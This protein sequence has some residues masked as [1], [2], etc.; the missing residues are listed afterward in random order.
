MNKKLLALVL[1]LST[2]LSLSSCAFFGGNKDESSSSQTSEAPATTYDLDGAKTLLESRVKTAN[3]ESRETYEV[4]ASILLEDVTYTI[5]WSVDVETVKI[6]KDGDKVY[7]NVYEASL[8]FEDVT[9][10]L[11][12]KI[13]APDGSTIES[14]MNRVVPKLER[15]VPAKITEKP[16]ENVAYKL[17]VYQGNTQKEVYAN[18]E[19]KNTWYFASTTDYDNGI[20]VYAEH[21]A[22][23]E[24]EF[25][26]YR[27]V[28][29]EGGA[30]VKEYINVVPNGSH[31]N[32]VYG[33]P[34]A[35]NFPDY[36]NYEGEMKTAYYFDTTWETVAT[37][38]N[39]I[40]YYFGCDGTYDTIEPQKNIG[41]DYF[42]GYLVTEV[43]R[44]NVEE[45]D[46]LAHEVTTLN[47]APAFI[48][49]GSSATLI[50]HG[51]RY[52]DVKI[53][54]AVNNE[55]ASI[56]RNE[57]SFNT[58]ETVQ[59]VTLTATLSIG[60]ATETKTLTFKVVPN[61]T[62][63]IIE[64]AKAFKSGE[65][66]GNDVTMTGIVL[67]IDEAYDPTYDS[68]SFT[69]W[70]NDTKVLGY[71]MKGE[72]ADVLAPGFTVT[73]DGKFM[74]YKSDLEFSFAKIESYEIGDESDIPETGDPVV[75][76][77][78]A[79]ILNALYGL[80]D[81]EELKGEFTLTGKITALDSYNNPTIVVEG[82]E[83]MPVYCYRL[84]V[85][86]KVGDIL[87]VTATSM[88]NYGGKYEFMNCT[89]VSSEAGSGTET[90][91]NPTYATPA[92]IL[93]ALYA[94]ADNET[95]T[96]E[97]TLT[98]KIT[99][100]DDYNNPTI[101][102]E[103]FENMPVYCY[104]L[105]VTNTINDVITVTATTMK[106]YQGKYEFMNCTLVSGDN[107][108]DDGNTDVS[109][110]A[111]DSTLTIPEAL[112]Y[113][114]T[115]TGETTAKYYVSGTITGFYHSSTNPTS[116]YTYGNVYITDDNNNTILVYGLYSA[117]GSV[118]YDAMTTKPVEG[119]Y[120]KVYGV[121][122]VY[123]GVG[124]FKNAWL[125]EHTAN[126]GN[127][128]GDNDNTDTPADGTTFTIPEAIAY[129]KTLA[130]N[131]TSTE[132]FYVA[133][134]ITGFYGSSG[135]TYG[136][137][138]IT[139]DNNNSILIYGLYNEDG[140]VKYSEMTTKPDEGDYIKVYGVIKNYY[141]TPQFVNGWVMEHTA[142]ELDVPE[143]EGEASVLSFADKT[144]RTTYTTSQQVW[145][146]NGIKVINDKAASTSNVGDYASPARFYKS[147]S[148]K[149]EATSMKTLVI[150]CNT[151]DYANAL[152]T[153]IASDANVTVNAT[154]KTVTIT[155]TNAV[156]S[157]SIA[158]LSAQVRVDS[159]S[160]YA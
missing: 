67:S 155:F 54:W 146:A 61:D 88:K 160:V 31:V 45:A 74:L 98:G 41:N 56:Y 129:G 134:T 142:G 149:I 159:I 138:Y 106:N 43:D 7:V 47:I 53:S 29:V 132:K 44:M 69:M 25:Y 135:T 39:G 109:A 60:E 111:A 72:G 112:A 23:S 18:G 52:P 36:E 110:P 14:K 58:V 34:D 145:E 26:L 10:V 22:T 42:M 30:Q 81:G 2:C 12:A 141:G 82:F 91:S 101:V 59:E 131:A 15:F 94:L 157:F 128:G 87:T 139:D 55:A 33:N 11:T 127:E 63:K 114:A 19:M 154:A 113:G 143:I 83:N 124:Q 21:V 123:N 103:G 17:N 51:D 66:F 130:E 126:S 147:S 3:A 121:L 105:Q 96:G 89:L 102:V 9:F 37:V 152:A 156:N 150:E 77:T 80:A 38:V 35:A 85:T 4:P 64:T 20:D 46:K 140:S 6:E 49:G 28:D 90:P 133:G 120:I 99:A 62:A 16:A 104:R 71:R 1:A 86:N 48:G 125:I 137:V 119:D 115:L 148:L 97:F 158:T 79:S 65:A 116:G 50:T 27:M 144:N 153:S 57:L 24:T 107:N 100:L 5:E 78:A 136:N 118:R 75:D 32:A 151:P 13:T 122:S 108:E 40:A 76:G 73:C 95:V 117:D 93:N 68:V 92:E 84:S 8:S 70:V